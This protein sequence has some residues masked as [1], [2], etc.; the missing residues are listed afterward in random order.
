MDV[1]DSGLE[2]V[3]LRRWAAAIGT[4][5]A[6]SEAAV[7]GEAA[8][9]VHAVEAAGLDLLARWSQPHRHYHDLRH[10]C[11][12]LD[13]VDALADLAEDAVA[14]R[15]AAWFHDA[16]YDGRPG[17]DE[18]ESAGLAADVLSRLLAAPG[19]VAEVRRLVELTATHH[20]EPGDVD[21]AVLCDADLA[22]LAAEP[23]RYA[24]YVAG[25]RAEY[26]HVS[27]EGFRSGRTRVLQGLLDAPAL[28]VTSRAH[29]WWEERA[30]QN[31]AAE[32]ERLA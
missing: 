18:R 11:E 30:R 24:E 3:L 28:F 2:T 6:P 21:G 14:V 16:V 22:I 20:A 12:V 31:V 32:L 25:V 7:P 15:L 26:A 19:Q 1:D 9:A 23:F 29:D 17:D 8:S 10:L 5:K 13:H 4:A 27:D